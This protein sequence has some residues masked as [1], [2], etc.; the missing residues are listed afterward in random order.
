[1]LEQ[2]SGL[3][4]DKAFKQMIAAPLGLSRCTLAMDPSLA[5]DV[6]HVFAYDDMKK[7]YEDTV[8]PANGSVPTYFWG[9]VWTDSGIQ[10]TATD[11]ARFTDALFGGKLVSS[12]SLAQMMKVGAVGYG[13]GIALKADS[14]SSVYGHAGSRF[15]Y[16]AAAWYDPARKLTIVALVNANGPTFLAETVYQRMSEAWANGATP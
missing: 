3:R 1:V 16:G 9:P 11:A 12:E 10:C 4:A 13:L 8:F 6:A 2:A 15:G 5:P 7:A 14:T